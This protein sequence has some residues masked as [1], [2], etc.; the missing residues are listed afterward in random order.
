MESNRSSRDERTSHPTSL[1]DQR[2]PSKAELTPETSRGLAAFLYVN[3]FAQT[4]YRPDDTMTPVR[5][6]GQRSG[7]MSEAA[8]VEQFAGQIGC[9]KRLLKRWT[10]DASKEIAATLLPGYRRAATEASGDPVR[11]N[12]YVVA[13]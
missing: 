7:P 3:M 9:S 2:L 12:E 1:A 13:L 11:W 10:D 4:A 8:R 5:Q 6:P